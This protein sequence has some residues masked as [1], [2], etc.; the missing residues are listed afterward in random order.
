MFSRFKNFGEKQS[1]CILGDK[2]KLESV[3][4]T[5]KLNSLSTVADLL[6]LDSDRGFHKKARPERRYF[7]YSDSFYPVSD[8]LFKGLIVYQITLGEA[9]TDETWQIR[10][11][12]SPLLL[13]AWIGGV[14]IFVGC[15]VGFFRRGEQGK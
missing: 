14:F 8:M 11:K 4:K 13:L 15:S 6:I 1:V 12:K 9:N 10:V 7:Y 5:P 2:Y 3:Y